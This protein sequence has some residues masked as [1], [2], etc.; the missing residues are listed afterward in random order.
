MNSTDVFWNRNFLNTSQMNVTDIFNIT[1]ELNVWRRHNTVQELYA[2]HRPTITS[3]DKYLTPLWYC[4]GFPSNI[5]SFLVWIQPS[6]RLSSGCYLAALA[7]ADFLFLV[8]QMVFELQEVW[9]FRTINYPFF[10][11]TFP[12]FFM[13]MQ[14][15]SPLLVLGFTIERYISICHPYQREKF[16][17]FKKALLYITILSFSVF[18]LHAIQGYFWTY[19]DNICTLRQN[20][21]AG[22]PKSV[23]IIWSWITELL[24][25]GVV[26]V[27]ILI[28]NI[29]VINTARIIRKNDEKRTMM[30]NRGS[31]RKSATTLTLLVVSF[32]L[33]FTTLPVTI[34]YSMY[35]NFPNGQENMSDDDISN[36][37]TWQHY[38]SYYMMR[39]LITELGMS[40]YA[41]NFFIY[42]FTGAQFRCQLKLLFVKIFCKDRLHEYRRADFLKDENLYRNKTADMPLNQY[43]LSNSSRTGVA[44]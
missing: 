19:V 16:C 20:I 15:M 11:E 3:I 28:L 14:Y 25:F 30:P 23:W 35:Y 5:L 26:P 29:L 36:D 21:T 44:L 13:A 32:Y 22:G 10:C 6:M 34:T 37:K 33:I 9:N 18:I 42:L 24:V 41:L 39:T 2:L 12:I 27:I 7:L 38:F 40:H 4:I 1:E 17:T 8:F 31:S 43:N